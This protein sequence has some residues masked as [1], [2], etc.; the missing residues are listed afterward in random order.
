[1]PRRLYSASPSK[2]LAWL[3]CPR[4]TAEALTPGQRIVGPAVIEGHTATTWVAP[5]W[6]AE[7]DPAD[8]LVLRRS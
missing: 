6:T 8:N 2:L 3:D 5:G 4:H 1:M 7:L